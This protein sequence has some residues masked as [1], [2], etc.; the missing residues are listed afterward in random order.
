MLHLILAK[1]HR[2]RR[3]SRLW[4]YSGTAS[5][6]AV[7]RSQGKSGQKPQCGMWLLSA[8]A[9]MAHSA[10]LTLFSPGSRHPVQRRRDGRMKEPRP[11]LSCAAAILASA[12]LSRLAVAR[13]ASQASQSMP[14]QPMFAIYSTSAAGEAARTTPLA[15]TW[16]PMASSSP[17]SAASPSSTERHSVSKAQSTRKSASRVFSSTQASRVSR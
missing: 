17:A 4:R 14:Q 5:Q 3:T 7:P 6:T 8:Q 16:Q 9:R 10:Q 11:S 12:A 2:L 13:L 1:T 15:R